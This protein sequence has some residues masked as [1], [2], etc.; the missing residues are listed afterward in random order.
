MGIKAHKK[1]APKRLNLGILTISTTRTIENDD[2]GKWIKKLARKEGHRVL[3]HQVVPDDAAAITRV[4]WE[5][6][7]ASGPDVVLLTGGTGISP[8]DVTIEAVRPMF[9]KELT[10]F[11]HLFALLSFEQIDA[12]ALLSRAAAGIIGKTV[13]FCM[14]GSLKACKL[15]ARALI[16]P[17]LG[18]L[19]WHA[20][21]EG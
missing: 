15:A 4:L 11:S 2:S 8:A 18:H 1:K 16:F 10:A 14:P 5:V 17:E 21:G 13:V 7:E 12:A 3:V 6:L 19:V 20:R 9:D